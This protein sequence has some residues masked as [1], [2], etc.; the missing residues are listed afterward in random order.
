ML[1]SDIINFFNS[2]CLKLSKKILKTKQNKKKQTQIDRS[3]LVRR[4]TGSLTSFDLSNVS[5]YISIITLV[6]QLLIELLLS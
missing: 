3:S 4:L 5:I 6:K 1:K 2:K